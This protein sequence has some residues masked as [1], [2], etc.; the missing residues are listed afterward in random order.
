MKRLNVFAV[1]LQIETSR[2]S[3]MFLVF[4]WPLL[5]KAGPEQSLLYS[6]RIELNENIVTLCFLS[7][8]HICI[9][10]WCC[11]TWTASAA[12]MMRVTD[13][14]LQLATVSGETS[15]VDAKLK[16]VKRHSRQ[17]ASRR[18]QNSCCFLLPVP[19]DMMHLLI[20]LLVP[21]SLLQI[22]SFC[23]TYKQN[24]K[25]MHCTY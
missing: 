2:V 22:R 7:L 16:E 23:T 21:L 8:T 9:L 11:D 20:F 10:C 17:E 25:R 12:V 18:N 3:Q 14:V 6:S 1:S 13:C 5:S 19:T 15:W 24:K 4:F